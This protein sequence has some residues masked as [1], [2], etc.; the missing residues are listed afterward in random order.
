MFRAIISPK[1]G[2][3]IAYIALF[4]CISYKGY[5]LGDTIFLLGLG[6][7]TYVLKTGALGSKSTRFLIPTLFLAIVSFYVPTFSIR[8]LLLIVALLFCFETLFGKLSELAFLVLL[9]MSP[10]FRYVSESFTF[11][12][13]IWLSEISGQIL[14]FLHLPV[15]IN[16][17]LIILSGNDFLV[18]AACT[19]LQMLGLSFLLCIFLLAY[20]QD[21]Y[22]RRI[23]FGWQLLTLTITFLFNIFSNLCRILLLI[24]FRITPDNFLHDLLGI[25]CLLVY[26]WLPMVWITKQIAIRQTVKPKELKVEETR[27]SQWLVNSLFLSV[28]AYLVLSFAGATTAQE[29]TSA[30]KKGKP[31]Y[32]IKILK[33]GITQLKSDKALIYLK[34]IPDFYSG[35]HSPIFCWKGSGYAF[36][37]IKEEVVQSYPIYTGVLINKKDKLYTAWWFTNGEIIT[38]SQ[39]DWRWR[40]LKGEHKFELINV[41][42]NSEHG[43][44]KVIAEWLK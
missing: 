41:T 8:Y 1:A 12:I 23:A 27:L 38:N 35:E 43:L 37:N 36:K 21:V 24:I 4:I 3:L 18:D 44:K 17:N 31:S 22:Q 29:L 19:G 40:V 5:F 7:L 33:T 25:C 16:G 10:L 42:A 26:V 6:I 39:L 34:P 15:E 32:Q 30:E 2:F 28:T 20:Y 9:L 11:P 14:A 13:R